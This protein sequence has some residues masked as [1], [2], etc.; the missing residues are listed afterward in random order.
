MHGV[1]RTRSGIGALRVASL[2]QPVQLSS[3]Q[4]LL[5]QKGR[6]IFGSMAATGPVFAVNHVCSP[7][8]DHRKDAREADAYHPHGV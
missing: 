6:A 5:A 8:V 3:L 2:Q 4:L 7:G 1:F